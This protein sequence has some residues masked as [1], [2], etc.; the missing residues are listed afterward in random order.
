MKSPLVCTPRD[1]SIS[2]SL[3]AHSTRSPAPPPWKATAQ[4][5][6]HHFIL[7]STLLFKWKY[8]MH[9]NTLSADI[10]TS[11][12]WNYALRVNGRQMIFIRKLISIEVNRERI[13]KLIRVLSRSHAVFSANAFLRVNKKKLCLVWW[14][15]L[16][17]GDIILKRNI[18]MLCITLKTWCGSESLLNLYILWEMWERVC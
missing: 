12:A 4:T 7:L 6:W 8:E 5:T 1:V 16:S 14:V 10:Y 11:A 15:N 18:Y 17:I 3:W 2:F 13:P 9:S